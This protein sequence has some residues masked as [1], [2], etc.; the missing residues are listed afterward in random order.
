[1]TRSRRGE[2]RC[3]EEEMHS[4]NL[5][6]SM[7]APYGCSL[8]LKVQPGALNAV[9]GRWVP[10]RRPAATASSYCRIQTLFKG[11]VPHSGKSNYSL[12]LPERERRGG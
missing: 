11:A 6:S 5:T 10:G 12:Y 1:M 9:R 7:R 2:V 4:M 8:L 3:E